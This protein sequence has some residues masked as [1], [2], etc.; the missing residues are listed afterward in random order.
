MQLSSL[1]SI[2]SHRNCVEKK[3]PLVLLALAFLLVIASK[4]V[5]WAF[6]IVKRLLRKGDDC[7]SHLSASAIRWDSIKPL[8]SFFSL[9]LLD[10]EIFLSIPH[11][12]PGT[13]I[14]SGTAGDFSSFR[15]RC[16]AAVTTAVTK[17]WAVRMKKTTGKCLS[18]C[19]G[20]MEYPNADKTCCY[21]VGLG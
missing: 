9:K 11:L 16:C 8:V 6:L 17:R 2:S 7:P 21:L 10:R 14:M 20:L 18:L 15:T 1:S 5:V 12:L 4:E 13:W 3:H 19:M